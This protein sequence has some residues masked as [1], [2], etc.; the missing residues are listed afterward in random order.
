VA[1]HA[2]LAR[3]AVKSIRGRSQALIYLSKAGQYDSEAL[4]VQ[5]HCA[6][7]ILTNRN[8]V[9]V[10]MTTMSFYLL[11]FYCLISQLL[12]FLSI[13]EFFKKIFEDLLSI[14]EKH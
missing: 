10:A 7:D 3:H 8:S 12:I 4:K 2:R 9:S 11:N 14:K 6:V 1:K 5:K 13:G